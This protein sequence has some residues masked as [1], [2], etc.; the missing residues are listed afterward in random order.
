MLL[1]KLKVFVDSDDLCLLLNT[2][3]VFSPTIG[4]MKEPATFY[5]TPTADCGAVPEGGA[6]FEIQPCHN[7]PP[8]D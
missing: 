2:L 6:K 8:C 4:R 5:G 1:L 7:I 3:F